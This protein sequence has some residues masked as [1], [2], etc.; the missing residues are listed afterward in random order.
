MWERSYGEGDDAPYSYAAAAASPEGEIIV[1]ASPGLSLGRAAASLPSKILRI[2]PEDGKAEAIEFPPP[3]LKGQGAGEAPVLPP[4]IKA[5]AVGEKGDAVVVLEVL[6]GRP[7]LLGIARDGK[8]VLEKEI[9]SPGRDLHIERIVRAS[10]GGFLLLGHES[11]DSIAIAVSGAGDVQWERKIDLGGTDFFVDG[12]AVPEG[13][14]LLVANAGEFDEYQQGP[15]SVL[16][17]KCDARGEVKTRMKLPGR[18]GSVVL[19][20]GGGFALVYDRSTSA[21]Q[22]VWAQAL[23]SDLNETW[24]APVLQIKQG[25][26]RFRIVRSPDGGYS[27]AGGKDDKPF[28]VRLDEAGKEIW[29]HWWEEA[30]RSL[31]YEILVLGGAEFVVSGIYDEGGRERVR[32]IKIAG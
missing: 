1:A 23:T 20:G 9:R 16:I 10:G 22:D 19:A 30:N 12:L 5:V 28:V 8:P 3:A 2:R 6:Q 21:A 15:S 18:H 32:L 13:G 25:F 24:S 7:W 4:A 11:A 27:I 31:D 26:S 17:L 14:F 29:R